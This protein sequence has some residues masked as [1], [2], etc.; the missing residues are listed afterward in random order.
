MHLNSTSNNKVKRNGVLHRGELIYSIGSLVFGAGIALLAV[1]ISIVILFKIHYGSEP[2]EILIS[3]FFTSLGV[4]LTPFGLN[5]MMRQTKYG[6]PIVC[7]S[8][9]MSLLAISVFTFTYPH[10]W[11]YPLIGYTLALY[12]FGFLT[13]VGNAFINVALRVI[14]G[15][16]ESI[17]LEEKKIKSYTDEEIKKDIDEALRSSTEIIA[18]ELQFKIDETD[19]VKLGKAFNGNC[20]TVIRV[21]D[22]IDEA[23]NLG[24]TISPAETEKWGSVGIEKDSMLLADALKEKTIK[25]GGFG[26]F[27]GR[28]IQRIKKLTYIM[29]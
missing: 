19:N 25:T 21:K 27:I 12:V 8:S 6:Y 10:S 24:H 18:S 14:E 16:S 13:M 22:D 28:F 26:A 29:K 11:F 5:I 7:V 2:E 17:D 15:S 1:G 9:F 4:S 20:S 23:K 3:I